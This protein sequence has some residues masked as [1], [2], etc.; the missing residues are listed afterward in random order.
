MPSPA[1]VLNGGIRHG[2][3]AMESYV[4]GRQLKIDVQERV[5]ALLNRPERS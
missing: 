1:T 2:V 3:L 5:Y 4:F